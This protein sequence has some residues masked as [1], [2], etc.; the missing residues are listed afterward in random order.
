MERLRTFVYP[1]QHRIDNLNMYDA[2]HIARMRYLDQAD[3]ENVDSVVLTGEGRAFSAGADIKEFAQNLHL[4]QPSLNDVIRRL[5]EFPKPVVAHVNGLALGGGLETALACHY[6]FASPLAAAGLPEVH[7]G[8]LPGAG[9]TQRLPRLISVDAAVQIMT[10]GR[11]LSATE[12]YKYGIFDKIA[13]TAFT[14]DEHMAQGVIDFIRTEKVLETPLHL[15]RISQQSVKGDVSVE[16]LATL[17]KSVLKSARGAD[18]PLNIYR[19]VVEGAIPL[20]FDAGLKREGELF[21]ELAMGH[22]AKALQYFFFTE[23]SVNASPK[24][25]SQSPPPTVSNVGVIGGGT[26]GAGIAM[27]LMNAEIPVTLVESS[28]ELAAKAIDRIRSTYKASSAYKTGKL[29]DDALRAKLQFITPAANLQAL[30]AS[31]MV[32]EAVFENMAV[33]KDIFAQL[34]KICKPGAILATNTSCLDVDEIAGATSEGRRSNVVGTHFFSPANIMRL[35]EIV[36]GK[37]TNSDSINACKMIG[38]KIG[39]TSVVAGNCYGFIGN[40]MLGPYGREAEFLVEEGCSPAQVDAALKK[41]GL[42]MGIFEMS[43]MAGNDVSWRQRMERGLTGDAV[44]K[45]DIMTPPDYPGMRYS[46]LGDKICEVGR[47]GQKTRGGWYEYLDQAPRVPVDSPEVATII[48][49]HRQANNITARSDIS[50]EEIIGRC[51][52]SLVNEGF[53]ILEEGFA[54][55]PSDIDVVYVYGYGFPKFLGGPMFWAE[56]R[57]GLP[58]LLGFLTEYHAKYPNQPW[59]EPSQLLRDVVRSG[60]SV[61]QYMKGKA[62]KE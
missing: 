21:Q 11:T 30:A 59:L 54:D 23:R 26:M 44:G 35:L 51:L 6:R 31:D 48:S 14:S 27:A 20:Q 29:T 1:F 13:P 37:E 2:H 46:I 52:Y 55:S 58:K 22:Q 3:K 41:L 60:Q 33:K 47:F 62:K 36:R 40:R 19:A 50:E 32:I 25:Q 9:G 8:I 45:V 28:D 12:A 15:R 7:L 5:D 10:S 61:S 18:A 43:D 17:K 16:A 4:K 39:K 38:K 34:D 49:A 56:N 24:S 53:K 42:A 57:V